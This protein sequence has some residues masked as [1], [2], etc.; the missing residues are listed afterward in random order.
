M[1]R[2]TILAGIALALIASLAAKEVWE[3][4]GFGKWT[5]REVNRVLDNSPWGLVYQLT[6]RTPFTAYLQRR[7]T[8]YY[9]HLRVHI[10]FLTAKPI[11]QALVRKL[12]LRSEGELDAS[13]FRDF[14]EQPN[15]DRIIV[16]LSLNSR[17]PQQLNQ[18]Q[19]Q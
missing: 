4:K 3:K 6:S 16:T 19:A 10:R 13:R 5:D 18:A 11:R 1:R 9:E 7:R 17:D 8:D 12:V 2:T 15:P 14:I